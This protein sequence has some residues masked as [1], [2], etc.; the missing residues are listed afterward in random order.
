LGIA[1]G[2]ALRADTRFRTP[3]R[4]KPGGLSHA[5]AS[6]RRTHRYDASAEPTT[7]PSL[8]SIPVGTAASALSS[9]ML[10]TG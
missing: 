5:W 4:A 10:E 7:H 6:R 2:S 8:H 9:I 1:L 3:R